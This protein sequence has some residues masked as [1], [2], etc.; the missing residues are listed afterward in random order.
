[1]IKKEKILFINC[2]ANISN[3]N[4]LY[5]LNTLYPKIMEKYPRLLI[6]EYFLYD[7]L[8]NN[9]YSNKNKKLIINPLNSGFIYNEDSYKFHGIEKNIFIKFGCD[10][11]YILNGLKIIINLSDR[12][13]TYNSSLN[14]NIIISEFYRYNYNVFDIFKNK[15]YF[16]LMNSSKNICKIKKTKRST[17]YMNATI[18]ELYSELSGEYKDRII[19][20][21]KLEYIKKCYYLI[22]KNN[23]CK[24]EGNNIILINI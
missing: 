12:I 20:K 18:E 8:N 16:C 4:N 7:P 3:K 24:P 19:P 10:I 17:E 21:E 23:N 22:G 1:M 14:L 9:N 6:I 13:I 5:K 11:K 15:K 2:Y